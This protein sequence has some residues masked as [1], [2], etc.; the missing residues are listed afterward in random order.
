[1]EVGLEFLT[2]LPECW[3]YSGM[4]PWLVYVVLGIRPR[5]LC[6]LSNN[7]PTELQSQPELAYF[8]Q[9]PSDSDVAGLWPHPVALGGV[10][11]CVGKRETLTKG[12]K[13]SCLGDVTLQM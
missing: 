10:L 12:Q 6:L 7:L 4:P 2:F 5:A 3:A 9:V 13:T 1:M 8:S 11:Y